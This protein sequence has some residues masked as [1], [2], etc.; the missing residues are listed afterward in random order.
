MTV[1]RVT[2][3]AVRTF[4]GLASNPL[5]RRTAFAREVLEPGHRWAVAG[6]G[7]LGVFVHDGDQEIDLIKIFCKRCQAQIGDVRA[8]VDSTAGPGAEPL[9]F[10]NSQHFGTWSDDPGAMKT[11]LTLLGTADNPALNLLVE[12]AGAEVPTTLES[13][14]RVHGALRM[15]TSDARHRAR[16]AFE[17]YK[18]SPGH[19]V[20]STMVGWHLKG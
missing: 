19:G 10:L 12:A 1:Q 3:G 7:D 2:H 20:E 6:L 18:E 11:G 8:V 14:C 15:A 13:D 5:D 16:L 4:S 17:T 9:F